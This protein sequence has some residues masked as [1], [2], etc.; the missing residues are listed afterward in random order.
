M[1]PNGTNFSLET[2]TLYTLIDIFTGFVSK[3]G[4]LFNV[5]RYQMSI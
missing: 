5:A 3:D 1:R 4:T 2:L